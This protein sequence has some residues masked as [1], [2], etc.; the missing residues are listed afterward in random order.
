MT[1]LP[2]LILCPRS[3]PALCSQ[4]AASRRSD[5]PLPSSGPCELCASSFP[6]CDVRCEMVRGAR[7]EMNQRSGHAAIAVPKP[8]PPFMQYEYEYEY[9]R[10]HALR[11]APYLISWLSRPETS[12]SSRYQ[13]STHITLLNVRCS[14]SE[15]R[16]HTTFHRV[17]DGR[18]NTEHRTQTTRPGPCHYHYS[19]DS[20]L[21]GCTLIC[22]SAPALRL[23]CSR[24]SWR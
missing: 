8:A 2:T 9:I 12:R 6:N 14:R 11:N 20:A 13:P 1:L 21:H 22:A 19:D 18:E 7:C 4:L 23:R 3:H 24:A 5:H 15:V 10:T 17:N 16:H